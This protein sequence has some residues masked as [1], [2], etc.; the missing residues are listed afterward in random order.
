M[1]DVT[2]YMKQGCPYCAAA[3]QH[4]TDAGADFE[5][6]DVKSDPE[7]AKKAQEVAGGSKVVPVIVD[8][9]EVKLGF[10]GS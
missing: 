4:Y 9:G 2:I 10:G 6:L 3:R 8:N 7:I 1:A 5:E